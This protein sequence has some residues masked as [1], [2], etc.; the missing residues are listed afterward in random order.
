MLVSC[1]MGVIKQCSHIDLHAHSMLCGFITS[2]LR[3]PSASGTCRMCTACYVGSSQTRYG[4]PLHFDIAYLS[5][6]WMVSMVSASRR[7]S[8]SCCSCA[9]SS[10]TADTRSKRISVAYG[11]TG[12]QVREAPSS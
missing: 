2:I 1:Y 3:Q 7:K 10:S 5:R 8:N 11:R 12:A 4:K 9:A 6:A